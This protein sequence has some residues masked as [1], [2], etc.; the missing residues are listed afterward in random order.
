MQMGESSLGGQT[1]G[2][3][4]LG[5][6]RLLAELGPDQTLRPQEQR[7]LA[8]RELSTVCR[9]SGLMAE[10]QLGP[11][12]GRGLRKRGR[13]GRRLPDGGSTRQKYV[14]ATNRT[15]FRD[16]SRGAVLFL[17]RH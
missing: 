3:P 8:V 11:Q 13:V 6:G 2:V 14:K 5:S 7:G 10:F 17:R 1:R 15:D 4:C 9:A 12:C 16:G